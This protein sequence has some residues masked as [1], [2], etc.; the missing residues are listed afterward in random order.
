MVLE[1][2]TVDHV[3]QILKNALNSMGVVVFR[4]DSPE[5]EKKGLLFGDR[6]VILSLLDILI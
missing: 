1:K 6:L 5:K 3:E 4:G 2:L